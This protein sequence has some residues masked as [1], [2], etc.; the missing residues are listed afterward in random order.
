MGSNKS[1]VHDST[2]EDHDRDNSIVVTTNI[3][4]IATILHIVC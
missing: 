3:K 1:D 4:H 2:Y